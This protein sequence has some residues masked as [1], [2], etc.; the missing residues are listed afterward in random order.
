MARLIE[1]QSLPALPEQI[2]L[3]VGDLLIFQASGGRVQLGAEAVELLG[4]FV[5][6]LLHESGSV[7]APMG[8]PNNV[9]F[10]ALSAGRASIDVIIGDP[11]YG[12]TSK[13][14]RVLVE[15]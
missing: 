12:S 14:I 13:T 5:P 10:R 9:L 4:A 7:L 3:S 8:A 1:A 11:W 6:S 15:T 2:T